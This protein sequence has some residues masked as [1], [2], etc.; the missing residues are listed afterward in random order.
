MVPANVSGVERLLVSGV[1]GYPQARPV[2]VL[3]RGMR[4]KGM[5]L[6]VFFLSHERARRW[7]TKWLPV[8]V[9]LD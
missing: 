6:D 8:T 4:I 2:P 9:Y 1:S 3:D 7:G 5:R